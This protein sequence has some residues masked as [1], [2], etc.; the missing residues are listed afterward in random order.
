[1]ASFREAQGLEVLDIWASNLDVKVAVDTETTGL[2]TAGGFDFAIGISAA[3]VVKTSFGPIGHAHYWAIAHETGENVDRSTYDKLAWVLENHTGQLVFANVIFDI[4][5]LLSVGIDIRQ[6]DIMDIQAQAHLIDENK[7]FQGKK[8]EY[9]AKFYL[10]EDAKITD[11]KWVEQEKKSGNHNI[12]PEEMFDYAVGDATATY[13]V[14]EVL[15]QHPE[16]LRLPTEI[17]EHKQRLIRVLVEMKSRGVGID[18][19]ETQRQEALGTEMMA[20][21]RAAVG[22]NPASQPQKQALLIDTLGLPILKTSPK[23]GNPSFDKS[24]MPTYEMMLEKD[25]NPL[26]KNLVAYNGWAKA[27][28]ASLRPFLR[29]VDPDGRLRCSYKLHGTVTG[30]FSCSEPNLQQIP[31]ESDKPWNGE[32]KRCFKPRPGRV[33]VEFDYSQLELRL[34]TAYAREPALR[35]IF[36]QGRDIFTEMSEQLGWDRQKTK[37]FVYSTQYGGGRQQTSIIFD[38]DVD[39]ASEY[40]QNYYSTYPAFKIFSNRCAAACRE[41]GVSV[42]WTKR[43]RHYQRPHKED[44]KAMNSVIQGGAADIVERIMVRVFEEIDNEDCQ[45]LLQI[46]DSLTFE[47]RE[48]VAEEYFDRIVE[49]M[50]DVQAILPDAL[51]DVFDVRFAVEG[52]VWGS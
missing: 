7:P 37:R 40:I 3:F 20:K 29:L 14:S 51:K 28:T 4:H 35:R 2:H 39:Q 5:S 10:G 11:D 33:L 38:V 15:D 30:R 19:E 47:I 48:E 26:A 18:I 16:W 46:H 25:D 9:L 50:E 52:K 36:E 32:I 6:A 24:V 49:M 43:H 23:T 8:L 1:M 34:A 31:K 41:N 45:L 42:L 12:T 13:R 21:Y 27:T 44:Y 17:W 22:I